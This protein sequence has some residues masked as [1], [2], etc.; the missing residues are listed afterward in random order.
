M[1]PQQL[2]RKI[3][4]AKAGNP[5]GFEALLGA[6]GPR[7]YGYFLRATGNH[8]DAE[9]LLGEIMLRLVRRL[10]DY[11]DRG[12]FEHWIFRIAANLV[13]DRIR[14]IRSAPAVGTISVLDSEGGDLSDRLPAETPSVD[15]GVLQRESNEH[16]QACLEKLDE[17]TRQMILLRH[18]G[19]MSF[20][21]L[22]ELFDCPLGTVLARVHRGM[23]VLRRLLGTE[24]ATD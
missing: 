22:A 10:K 23:R 16:L 24:D 12:R 13:R 14:R 21:D 4:S 2:R 8:H 1:D 6:F 9:D 7:L 19:R 15:A 5:A 20:K 3:A 11:D 18:L 17:T